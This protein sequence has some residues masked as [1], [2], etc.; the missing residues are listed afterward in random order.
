MGGTEGSAVFAATCMC[1]RGDE[2]GESFVSSWG[3][4]H[5]RG[6]GVMCL[7]RSLQ[8]PVGTGSRGQRAGALRWACALEPFGEGG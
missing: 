3:F 1:H 4:G 8:L 7:R 5:S 2:G 6:T